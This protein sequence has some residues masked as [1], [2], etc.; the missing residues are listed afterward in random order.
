MTWRER[1]R[2]AGNSLCRS[3][4]RPVR[5]SIRRYFPFVRGEFYV[6]QLQISAAQVLHSFFHCGRARLSRSFHTKDGVLT[7]AVVGPSRSGLESAFLL[8]FLDVVI[9]FW[10]QVS[11]FAVLSPL[12]VRLSPRL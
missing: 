7:V 6:Q 4:L 12:C 9:S 8:A 1:R 2:G 11:F 3:S 10:S 5:S